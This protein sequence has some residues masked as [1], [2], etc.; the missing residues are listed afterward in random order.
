MGCFRFSSIVHS[1][2]NFA[3]WAIFAVLI[4]VTGAASHISTC[5][6]ASFFLI[7]TG[8]YID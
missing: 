6:P 4:A 7:V 3:P 2:G 8:V 5:L 1:A